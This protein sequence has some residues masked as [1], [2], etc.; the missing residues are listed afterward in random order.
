MKTI[1]NLH[2]DAPTVCKYNDWCSCECAGCTVQRKMREGV[3]SVDQY[4]TAAKPILGE[5]AL[6]AKQSVTLSNGWT[7]MTA[8]VVKA[9]TTKRPYF[10]EPCCVCG[11][12]IG[13]GHGDHENCDLCEACFE[14]AGFENEHSDTGGQ[15]VIGFDVNGN[16][17]TGAHGACPDCRAEQQPMIEAL[18]IM[19]A[20][21]S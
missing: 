18:A 7:K 10:S 12:P 11:K 9:R 14:E 20:V 21:Q 6:K 3:M 13:Q 1:R 19:A 5:I 16:E 4:I 17:I 2:C 8:K 15:H